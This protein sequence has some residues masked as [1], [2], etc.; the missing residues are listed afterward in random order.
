MTKAI[1]ILI[2]L[3]VAYM[4]FLLVKQWNRT[5]LEHAREEKQKTA[6]TINAES[7]PGMPYGL[8][9][10]LRTAKERGPR[11]FQDWFRAN[12]K[13]LFDPRKA[14]IEMELC[15]AMTREN[16][17]EAKRIFASV[18]GRTPPSSPVWPKVKELERTFQ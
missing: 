7:L 14:W 13:S 11:A 2:G 4:A 1:W 16:P 8:E 5:Q 6:A 18:K 9:S 10:G 17:A 15:V 12:E 3:V